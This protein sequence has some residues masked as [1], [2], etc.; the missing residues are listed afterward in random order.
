MPLRRFL[1]NTTFGPDEIAC[2]GQAF[3]EALRCLDVIDR[4]SPAAEL[5]AKKII[6]LATQGER[7]P[8]RLRNRAVE[9]VSGRS[10][11]AA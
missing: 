10:A 8:M 11:N 9:S 7:D 2:M 4:T 3:E 5:L 6:E 1:Q